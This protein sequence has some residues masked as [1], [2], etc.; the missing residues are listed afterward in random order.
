MQ[1]GSVA[2]VPMIVTVPANDTYPALVDI[3]LPVNESAVLTVS[4]IRVT[5]P[6]RNIVCFNIT[7][8]NLTAIYNSSLAT[9]QKDKAYLDLGII[10]NSGRGTFYTNKGPFSTD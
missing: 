6:G 1:P 7:A 8:A 9:T 4:D 2:T 5:S 10:T 3:A